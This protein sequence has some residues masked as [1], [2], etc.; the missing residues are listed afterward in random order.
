MLVRARYGDDAVML[1]LAAD[2]LIRDEAAF[3]AAVT[4]AA[5]MARAGKLVTF[6]I[7]PTL[8]ET[9]YGYIECGAQLAERVFA[10]AQ[11]VEK[12]P[13]A[14]AREY[15]V[16]GNYVWNS[17]MFA[18]TPAAILAAFERYAPAVLAA[19]R[20]VWQPLSAHAGDADARDRRG[21]LRGHPRPVDRLRGD[22]EGRGRRPRG[23][24]ARRLRL[25]RRRI[26]AGGVGAVRRGCRRQPRQRR[27]RRHPDPRHVR[28]FARTASSRR[29]AS[30]TSSSST[31]RT[32]CSSRIAT[33]C[34]A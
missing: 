10:A 11:F 1:V 5:D 30:R 32:R 13:L 20:T 6:G 21:E 14:K 19:A 4:R 15:L 24:R 16:A 22:G 23:G 9:G 33:T 27:A 31:R 18:F 2:H 28:A 3:G 7:T 8:P 25:E 12:P 17:G 34:S 26:V 29:S